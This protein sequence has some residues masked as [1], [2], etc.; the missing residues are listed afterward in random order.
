MDK[1]LDRKQ[2]DQKLIV[3][4]HYKEI[5]GLRAMAVI[6]VI[7]FHSALIASLNVEAPESGV[8]RFYYEITRA[9]WCGVDLFFV[10]SGFLI[11]G[12]L[13]DTAYRENCFKYFYIRRTVR[14]FPLYYMV[15]IF[16]FVFLLPFFGN[17][18]FDTRDALYFLYLQNWFKL[19]GYN[20]EVFFDHFWSLA[21]E[22]QFYLV[23]PALFVFAFR[24][25]L[26]VPL[27]V[28]LIVFAVL[29][30]AYLVMQ[31][32]YEISYTMTI[33]RIDGLVLGA[34]L[35]YVLRQKAEWD[36]LNQLFK[37]LVG[38]PLA[39]ICLLAFVN[40]GLYGQDHYVLMYGLF[41]FALMFTGLIGWTVTADK[42]HWFM[43]FLR[44]KFMLE[45]GRVSY[46]IY[47]YHWLVMCSLYPFAFLDRWSFMG[48]HLFML[49]FGGGVTYVLAW[50][51]FKYFEKPMLKLKDIYANYNE[52]TPKVR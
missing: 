10:I 17:A 44:L 4:R 2:D 48:N 32:Q 40:G 15:L 41:L 36:G 20:S 37:M 13:M 29:L 31:G 1:A 19:M 21:V 47:V 25:S 50:L 49:F 22:E 9:G 3:G 16:G 26:A 30:R 35:A 38:F 42:D 52:A 5:D 33:T 7:V 51:S 45:I 28:G 43:R 23:W 6:L 18:D 12:I 14:I 11:T 39:G 24:K 27:C 46:G 8:L 34:L